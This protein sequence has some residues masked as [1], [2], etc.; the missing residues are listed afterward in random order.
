VAHEVDSLDDGAWGDVDECGPTLLEPTFPPSKEMDLWLAVFEEAL[1]D[2]AGK[3][4]A[5]AEREKCQREVAE[6]FD[7]DEEYTGSCV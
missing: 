2:L 7:S 5:K 3:S 1:F 6:W 4:E